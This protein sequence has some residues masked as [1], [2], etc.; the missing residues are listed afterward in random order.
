MTQG[1]GG[2]SIFAVQFAKA[3]GARVIATTSSS[4]K[5]EQL[6]KL[7]ADH[8]I[9][10]KEDANWGESAK[11]LTG[12]SGV[13]HVLE[14][15]GPSTMKQSLNAIAIEGVISIIGF[16]GGAK[17]DNPPG[18]MDCL[19]NIC[20]VRGVLVGSRMQFEE[21]NRAIEANDIKPVVDSKVFK[22][23][24]TKEAYQVSFYLFAFRRMQY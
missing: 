14:V 21:M 23:A 9:N 6:K 11:K 22:L 16:L 15:G 13:Q 3:A 18:F 10:Y 7:G 1:T 8:I 2:V 24:E 19:M 17:M 4:E 12:G 20:T 5:A